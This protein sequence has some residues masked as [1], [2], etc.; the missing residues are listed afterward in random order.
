MGGSGAFQA[1][2]A[3]RREWW[4]KPVNNLQSPRVTVTEHIVGRAGT[5][6]G[7]PVCEVSVVSL[8]EALAGWEFRPGRKLEPGL[9]HGS[10]AV[11]DPRESR[12][13]DHA[14][15]DDN[16]RRHPGL[17][18]L[19]DWCWGGDGQWLYCWTDDLKVYSHDHGWY[20]PETGPNWSVDALLARWDEAHPLA[21]ATSSLPHA[22]FLDYAERLE[23]VSRLQILNML[24]GIPAAWPVQDEELEVLGFF[25]EARTS[26]VAA[27]L[28]G[29]GGS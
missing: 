9:A 19:Y 2:D 14:Q 8:P 29:M 12:R 22:V 23:A 16:G 20:F 7:A 13:L 24:N 28:R 26:S 25:L 11:P 18:A 17:F 15:R 27:R 5:L 1:R 10:R 4:V 3:D 6:I 21:D